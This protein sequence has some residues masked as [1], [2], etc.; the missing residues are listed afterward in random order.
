MFQDI[1]DLVGRRIAIF[2]LSGNPPTGNSGHRGIVSFLVQTGHFDEVWILPVYQHMYSAKRS[3]VS[4]EDRVTMCKISMEDVSQPT[5]RV[6][7]VMVEKYAADF[8]EQRKGREYRVGT[9]DIIDFINQH[10][11]GLELSL[12]LGTDTYNDLIGYKWKNSER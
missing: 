3:M 1:T 8:Y 6:R 2:G 10:C 5:C 9:I 12:V 4:Y 11:P 7:V